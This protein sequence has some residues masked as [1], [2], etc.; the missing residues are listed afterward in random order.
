MLRALVPISIA[1][2]LFTGCISPSPDREEIHKVDALVAARMDA[3][4]RAC[5]LLGIDERPRVPEPA[6]GTALTLEQAIGRALSRNFALVASAENLA[7]AQAQLAQA[8]LLSNPVYVFSLRPL[9]GGGLA[10]FDEAIV[11]TLQDVITQPWRVNVAELQRWQVG[12]DLAGRAFE[13]GLDVESQWNQLAHLARSQAIAASDATLYGRAVTAADAR[14]KVGLILESDL[15]RARLQFWDAE[16]QTRALAIQYERAARELNWLMGSG[17]APPWRLPDEASAPPGELPPIP[18]VEP[19]EGAGTTYRLDLVRADV[20]R[21]LGEVN[22]ALAKLGFIPNVTI[23]FDLEK[24]DPRDSRNK[25]G[26]VGSVEIPIFDCGYVG[27]RLAE[28]GERLAQKT[29]DALLGQ[30]RQDVRTAWQ[31]L[32]VAR[33]DVEFYRDRLVPA[34]LEN[35]RLAQLAFDLGKLDLDALLNTLHDVVTARQ[36][37]E[38]ALWAYQDAVVGLERAT[39]LAWARLEQEVAKR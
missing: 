27:Y 11:K 38:A 14:A 30:V 3:R 7:I 16:R 31:N 32:R 2:L 13:L 5:E 15:N 26:V 22:I 37:S 9:L 25:R 34:Q 1:A 4:F 19:L 18:D 33:Y 10:D 17:A 8:G 20:D 12:I 21:K 24:T 6:S 35:A 29:Y 36:A 23:G 39:G 28:A